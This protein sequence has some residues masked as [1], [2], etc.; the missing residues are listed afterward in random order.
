MV[1]CPGN[2]NE[3]IAGTEEAVTW[4]EPEFTDN[5][6][7]AKV[8]S[9]KK[10]GDIFQLGSTNV[11]YSAFDETGNVARCSFVVSLARKSLAQRI[12]LLSFAGMFVF[13]LIVSLFVC[14]IDFSFLFSLVSLIPFIVFL[15]VRLCLL[16]IV[17]FR[18]SVCFLNVSLLVRLC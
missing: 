1:Y 8:E 11:E 2:V 10:S 18:L 5:V 17:P 3:L 12:L 13:F 4:R 16:D 9:S 6:K 14:L 15:I 7:V